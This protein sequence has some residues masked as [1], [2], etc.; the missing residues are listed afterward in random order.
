MKRTMVMI[1]KNGVQPKAEHPRSDFKE[2]MEERFVTKDGKLFSD[3]FLA[4]EHERQQDLFMEFFNAM[5]FN[6]TVAMT[7][8]EI[9]Q[10]MC[11]K[12]DAIRAVCKMIRLNAAIVHKGKNVKQEKVDSPKPMKAFR[13]LAIPA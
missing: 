9:V 8:R 2:E 1:L 4:K 7:P 6:G 12:E 13:D 5:G 11:L 10:K 3:V